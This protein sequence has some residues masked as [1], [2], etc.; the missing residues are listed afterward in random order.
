MSFYTKRNIANPSPDIGD[1]FGISI[2]VDGDLYVVGAEFDDTDISNGGR[3]YVYN[4][5]TDELVYTLVDPTP[6]TNGYFGHAVDINSDYIV[7]SRPASYTTNDRVHVYDRNTGAFL[8]TITGAT[9]QEFGTSVAISGSTVL[10]GA[11]RRNG[12]ANESGRAY[13]YSAVNGAF[14]ANILDPSPSAGG[15]FGWTAAINENY[16]VTSSYV[17]GG[18]TGEVYVFNSTDGTLLQTISNPVAQGSQFGESLALDGDNIVIGAPFYN[19]VQL[20]IG[21]GYLY[22][23]ST[24][25]L[26]QTFDNIQP[27]NASVQ[28]GGAAGIKG[29]LVAF[30]AQSLGPSGAGQVH[31]YYA[32]TG[33]S[34]GLIAH[35]DAASGSQFG[36]AIDIDS[37]EI[38]ATA[39]QSNPGGVNDAGNAYSFK[40]PAV[41]DQTL[42]D[43][44]KVKLRVDFEDIHGGF[45]NY[46]DYSNDARARTESGTN[47]FLTAGKFGQGLDVDSGTVTWANTP[48]IDLGTDDFCFEGWFRGSS[49]ENGLLEATNCF[50]LRRGPSLTFK[51]FIRNTSDVEVV[52][53]TGGTISNI[54]YQHVAFT[55]QGSTFR[56]F[57][58][59]SLV[60][61]GTSTDPVKVANANLT[62]NQ[63]LDVD[64]IRVVQGQA[65]YTENFVVPSEAL[66]TEQLTFPFVDYTYRQEILAPD[67]VTPIPE[68]SLKITEATLDSSFIRN[69]KPDGSDIRITTDIDGFD[70]LPVDVVALE[71][72]RIEIRTR[73]PNYSTNNRAIFV[74]AGNP[75]AV[76]RAPTDPLGRNAV[77]PNY[78]YMFH[79]EETAGTVA[80]NSAG[81]INGTY[82]DGWPNSVIPGAQRGTG[83]NP[84]TEAEVLNPQLSAADWDVTQPWTA[85]F[86]FYKPFVQS[87]Q[88]MW[89]EGFTNNPILYVLLNGTSCQVR[90]SQSA[91]LF[92]TSGTF[93][94]DAMNIVNISYDGG[95][96]YFYDLNGVSIQDGGAFGV[97]PIAD[98]L[99][100]NIRI[101]GGIGTSTFNFNGDLYEAS[102]ITG[103]Q[104]T[105]AEMS[106]ESNNTLS[107][108]TFYTAG[109]SELLTDAG[110]P[111][112]SRENFQTV[113]SYL[114]ESFGLSGANNDIIKEWL[115]SEGHSGQLNDAFVKYWKD[116]GYTGTFNDM[117][118]QWKKDV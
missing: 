65:V 18:N 70:E 79:M 55:R 75:N 116:L 38:F 22:S 39:P 10:I 14:I 99:L 54:T 63:A 52:S 97:G 57:V 117:W 112:E 23:A 68:V 109:P 66:P 1:K 84:A 114:V 76:A 113:A 92:S 64:D 51:G 27:N 45:K 30:G 71:E 118:N 43:F 16:A 91:M 36:W 95:T 4:R 56:L 42:V 37:D 61:S 115:A 87:N 96:Q 26:L 20:Q 85:T 15:R 12:G 90:E 3:A 46:F 93:F 49:T 9:N 100:G 110:V 8:R 31:T 5:D 103:R 89:G 62:I 81:G 34:A 104:K 33:A 24:G 73:L 53:L 25:A 67:P 69:A 29:N 2:A 32:D 101:G 19:G 47:N 17:H 13:L 59:G 80:L 108:E 21:Q 72:G 83:A 6:I 41:V 86:V 82:V 44:N 88:T 58:N 98:N 106:T 48:V 94:N 105:Q 50:G 7:V 111:V 102:L 35:P 60:D 78:R 77:Y 11:W 74:R 28:M 40:L 107:P